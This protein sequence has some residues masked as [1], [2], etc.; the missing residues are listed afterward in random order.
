MGALIQ[1]IQVQ[2]PINRLDG[3][4]SG[5]GIG[6]QLRQP[7][8]DDFHPLV[9]DLAPHADPVVEVGSVAQGEPFEELA[10]PRIDSVLE[11]GDEDAPFLARW[12]LAVVGECGVVGSPEVLEIQLE[13]RGEVE[14]DGIALDDQVGFVGY[15]R[16]PVP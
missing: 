12:A 16:E 13:I 2:P 3:S 15:P 10:T 11:P 1:R 8:E 14:P 4:R 6:L 7:L 9:P 5:P